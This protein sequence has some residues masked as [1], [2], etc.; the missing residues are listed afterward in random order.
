[1]KKMLFRSLMLLCMTLNTSG[2][3]EAAVSGGA[4][5]GTDQATADQESPVQP[6]EPEAGQDR[7][8]A[9]DQRSGEDRNTTFLREQGV[10]DATSRPGDLSA[11]G[12]RGGLDGALECQDERGCGDN[13]PPCLT[14]SCGAGERCDP[15]D[16]ACVECLQ[17]S[18]CP[19]ERSRCDRAARL[20]QRCIE[21]AD[22]SAESPRCV[23]GECVACRADDTAPDELCRDGICAS[24][25]GAECVA[26]EWR[27]AAPGYT[28]E[29]DLCDGWD[30]DCDGVSDEDC[31]AP[32]I[33]LERVADALEAEMYFF[34]IDPVG[35]VY[36]SA[37][38]AGVSFVKQVPADPAEEV[39]R[40]MGNS[41][42]N[43]GDV[44]FNPVTGELVLLG[45]GAGVEPGGGLRVYQDCAPLDEGCGCAGRPN[46]PGFSYEPLLR[47]SYH[48]V[49]GITNGSPTGVEVAPDGSYY[50]SEFNYENCVEDPAARDCGPEQPERWCVTAEPVRCGEPGHGQLAHL[51]TPAE[52]SPLQWQIIA[53]FPDMEIT[54]MALGRDGDLL[55]GL[56]GG[57]QDPRGLVVY[58]NPHTRRQISLLELANPIVS[59]ANDPADGSWYIAEFLVNNAPRRMSFHRLAADGSVLALPELWRAPRNSSNIHMKFGPDGKLY[60]LMNGGGSSSID[61]LFLR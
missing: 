14:I 60:R 13:E 24:A 57:D 39:T 32:V 6:S 34:E 54:S 5:P 31:V 29:R 8:A 53:R 4:A 11:T 59:I 40:L 48:R 52:G 20:C 47:A 43:H 37:I 1:M 2:C 17:D 49:Y 7:S 58:F 16:G 50:L 9:F 21:D 42:H 27:C 55:L 46:C 18:D 28:H 51:V 3:E 38:R 44:E 45:N 23:L 33:S 41:S 35:T 36:L 22:C 25:G 10:E 26:G 19:G 12:E 15:S 61:A 56:Y 30:S